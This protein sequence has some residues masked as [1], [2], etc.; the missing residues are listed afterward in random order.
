MLSSSE[1]THYEA[2]DVDGMAR[3]MRAAFRHSGTMSTVRHQAHARAEN[4][5]PEDIAD[6]AMPVEVSYPPMPRIVSR[7]TIVDV[8][9]T[10]SPINHFGTEVAQPTE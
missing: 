10:T 6:G 2:A 5:E 3:I 8:S 4:A 9:G 7:N 1:N